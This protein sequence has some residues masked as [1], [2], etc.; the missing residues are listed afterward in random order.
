MN[1]GTDEVFTSTRKTHEAT[2]VLAFIEWLDLHVEADLE[3][4]VVL[5]N[6]SALKAPPAAKWV[7]NP[8]RA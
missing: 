8:N 5:V 1:L 6:L 7:S 3:T 4:Y 2:D